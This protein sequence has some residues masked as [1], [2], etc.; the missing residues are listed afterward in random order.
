MEYK[1]I[2]KDCFRAVEDYLCCSITCGYYVGITSVRAD[3][4]D[5]TKEKLDELR[6]SREPYTEE[7]VAQGRLQD[8]KKKLWNFN[9]EELEEAGEA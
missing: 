3:F 2:T 5:P 1:C 4:V 7:H 6:A 8:M 9:Q